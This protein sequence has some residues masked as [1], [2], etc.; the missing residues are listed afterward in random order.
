[1][2]STGAGFDE[3]ITSLKKA[4]AALRDAGVPF[5]LAGGL[6]VWV[7]GSVTPRDDDIDLYVKREDAEPGLAVLEAAGMRPS[8]PPEEWLVKAYDGRVLIDLIFAP[9]GIEVDDAFFE[10]CDSLQVQAVTMPVVPV[11][12][13][14]GTQLLVQ[15]EHHLDFEGL[16]EMCR[17]VREQIDWDWVR[18]FTKPSPFARAF[19][20]LA[21]EL[22]I[23]PASR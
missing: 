19:I 3:M 15:N 8:R 7:R 6:A 2:S 22:R 12:V 5:A 21:E 1:M 10:R 16:L 13:V 4:A 11:D 23:A 9:T 18:D 14:V 20:Y 17:A